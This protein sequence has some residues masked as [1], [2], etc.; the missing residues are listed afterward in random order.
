[1][2]ELKLVQPATYRHLIFSS[3]GAFDTSTYST[4]HRVKQRQVCWDK[5]LSEA[6]QPG[7]SSS[8]M[9]APASVTAGD[10]VNAETPNCSLATLFQVDHL[11][12][13]ITGLGVAVKPVITAASPG[14]WLGRCTSWEPWPG[15]LLLVCFQDQIHFK[16][17]VM[18]HK[19]AS[20]TSFSKCPDLLISNL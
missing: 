6:W 7:K 9:V 12:T 2:T 3:S 19:Q 5:H 17:G 13:E 16:T 8:M 18:W 4:D 14:R 15:L 1:M 20:G 11:S 10:Q